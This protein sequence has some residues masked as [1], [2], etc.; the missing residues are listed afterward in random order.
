MTTEFTS[1]SKELEPAGYLATSKTYRFRFGSFDKEYESFRGTA[2]SVRYFI[3]VALLRNTLMPILT[4]EEDFAVV[5]SEPAAVNPI[6]PTIMEIA[7]EDR[8]HI[9][10]QLP[11]NAYSTK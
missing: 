4:E 11:K 10:F 8:L 6:V 1:V 7:F 2:G 3:R 5:V 9:E